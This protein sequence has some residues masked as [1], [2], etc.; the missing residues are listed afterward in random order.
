MARSKTGSANIYVPRL[1]A[2]LTSDPDRA[3]LGP[4]VWQD[5][6]LIL[7]GVAQATRWRNL[8]TGEV[9]TAEDRDGQPSLAAADIFAG[10]PVAL[11]IAERDG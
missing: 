9:L 10:F 4:E 2:G 5:T 6:R 1:V 8:F 3:P 7:A 11:L